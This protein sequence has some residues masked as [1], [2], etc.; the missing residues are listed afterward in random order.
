MVKVLVIFVAVVYLIAFVQT[1]AIQG[2]FEETLNDEEDVK[3]RTRRSIPR[4]IYL[5]YLMNFVILIF[6]F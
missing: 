4:K 6:F 3:N 2:I 5:F 1:N